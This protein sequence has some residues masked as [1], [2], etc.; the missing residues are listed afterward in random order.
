VCIRKLLSRTFIGIVIGLFSLSA[1]AGIPVIDGTSIAQQIQQVLAWGQQ[2]QQMV[3]QLN[4]LKEQFDQLKTMTEKLDGARGLGQILQDA[5]IANALPPE[6]RDAAR[7]LANPS[8]L[9]SNQAAI[10]GILASFGITQTGI[11]SAAQLNADTLGRAQAILNATQLRTTQ[12]QGLAARVDG[13]LDAKE[14]LDLLNRNTLE[15]ATIQNQAVQTAAALE[16]ARQQEQLALKA[17]AQRLAQSHSA[18]NSATPP[19]FGR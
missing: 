12:L 5:A 16:A 11:V 3:D 14:S 2:A 1:K 10:S 8:A 19:T 6:M 7:L 4:K 18:G 17:R 13:S 15:V 9:S